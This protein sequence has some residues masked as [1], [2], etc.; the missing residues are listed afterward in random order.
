MEA[1]PQIETAFVKKDRVDSAK[2][3]L[4]EEVIQ[5]NRV[6][7]V[8]KGGRRFSFSALVVVGD[9]NGH[10]GLGFGKANEVPESIQKGVQNAKKN[11]IVVPRVGRTI[12]HEVY[13][14]FGAACVMLKPASEGTGII[15]GPAIRSVLELGG[16][17]DVLTKNLGSKNV[18]NIL[19]A[20]IEGLKNIRDA[21]EVM[22]L[23][24]KSL[25][26]AVGKRR[27]KALRECA[28]KKTGGADLVAQ[29]RERA[30]KIAGE[31]GDE[32]L[33]VNGFEEQDD[34]SDDD[35]DNSSER[36]S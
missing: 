27:A 13:G 25:E 6:A 15:A 24:G 22:R 7:K 34:D 29:L 4:T 16:V 10:V 17:Q 11:L 32:M 2:L 9:K 19:K 18:I 23:R 31:Q 35:D 12:P 8:V 26:D 33:V 20:V 36:G 28:V 14:E 21:E 1:S 30:E 5:L 3:E